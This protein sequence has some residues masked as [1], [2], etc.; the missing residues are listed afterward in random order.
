MTVLYLKNSATWFFF[1]FRPSPN[2]CLP[3]ADSLWWGNW[4]GLD[5][6]LFIYPAKGQCVPQFIAYF[7]D[8][9]H[10]PCSFTDCFS[11]PDL[12]S[13]IVL[14]LWIVYTP[15]GHFQPNVLLGFNPVSYPFNDE[16][17]SYKELY[18]MTEPGEVKACHRVIGKRTG[19]TCILVYTGVNIV[20]SSFCRWAWGAYFCWWMHI[21]LYLL[22]IL[23]HQIIKCINSTPLVELWVVG[24]LFSYF[25]SITVL[26]S[27]AVE[28]QVH[29]ILT[30]LL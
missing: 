11:K 12:Q 15:Y 25:I 17:F 22:C 1:F 16:F 10:V 7:P 2:K 14:C 23:L 29:M 13:K 5:N 18:C 3:C 28:I 9:S 19:L 8:G 30:V 20:F 24:I 27:Q 26:S 21:F 4:F 6:M